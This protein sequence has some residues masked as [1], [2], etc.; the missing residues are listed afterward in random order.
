MCFVLDI[1]IFHCIFSSN[2]K[3]YTEFSPLRNWL[4]SNPRTSLVVGG[5]TYRN[6]LK[7]LTKYLG[8]LIE[9]EKKKK[10]TKIS[11]DVV[12]AEEKRV[13]SLVGHR[14]FD[15]PHIV[16]IF[17]ASRCRIFASHD[18]RSDQFIKRKEFYPKGQKLPRIYRNKR[19][20]K[21][22]TEANI[23]PLHNLCS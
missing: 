16:A 18:K 1:N 3:E 17:C 11:N 12:D 22:L 5:T 15:D 8:M 9:L 4:F 21:L 20:Q 6:E 19:H 2:S 7:Q 14:D 23:V 10:I 13:R